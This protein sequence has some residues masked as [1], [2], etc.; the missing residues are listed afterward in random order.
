MP[1]GAGNG[2][3]AMR[4][5]LLLGIVGA[6]IYA[7]LIFTHDV[8]TDGK[9]EHTYAG[10]T[11]PDHPDANRLSSWD[12]YLPTPS[13]NSYSG[14]AVTGGNSLAAQP[15]RVSSWVEGYRT[16]GCGS[17][18]SHSLGKERRDSGDG[19]RHRRRNASGEG[20]PVAVA[21]GT[22][23]ERFLLERNRLSE[24]LA[25]GNSR[26]GPRSIQGRS[27]AA[28]TAGAADVQGEC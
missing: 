18:T 21:R 2:N 1:T 17:S 16:R 27:P 25:E 8:I 14:L 20:G 13:V 7:V 11:Q 24:L 3:L 12:G 5:L 19:G 9:T 23:L 10:Q 15:C 4:G 22:V 6:A 28:A 26:T